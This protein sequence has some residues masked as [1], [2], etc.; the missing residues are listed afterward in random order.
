MRHPLVRDA[1]TIFG[2][3]ALISEAKGAHHGAWKPSNSVN[4]ERELPA[5]ASLFLEAVK[6][7]AAVATR[8]FVVAVRDSFLEVAQSIV[9][10][11]GRQRI[12]RAMIQ[13]VAESRPQRVPLQERGKDARGAEF[14]PWVEVTQGIP[15]DDLPKVKVDSLKHP[16]IVV[17]C[18]GCELELERELWS[19]RGWFP[20]SGALDAG[21]ECGG[22]RRPHGLG[23]EWPRL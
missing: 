7:D 20:R 8:G 22:R 21:Q 12:I 10:S 6:E 23:V 17:R 19:R 2:Q 9:I 3:P 11:K 1:T 16:L 15:V 4:G 13:G 5:F 18:R 14:R